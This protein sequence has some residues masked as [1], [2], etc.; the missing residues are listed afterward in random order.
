MRL[1][2]G[3]E[4]KATMSLCLCL[5]L[6]VRHLRLGAEV[7]L[8]NKQILQKSS[9]FFKQ[10][11]EVSKGESLGTG[12]GHKPWYLVVFFWSSGRYS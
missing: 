5:F 4:C 3:L 7:T 1:S 6:R 12:L 10:Y 11:M 9:G 2:P 8:P